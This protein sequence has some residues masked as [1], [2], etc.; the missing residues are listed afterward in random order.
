MGALL[1]IEV[2]VKTGIC[3]LERRLTGNVHL[4]AS[5]T[6]WP[7]GLSKFAASSD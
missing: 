7:L 5:E 4:T 2:R 6:Q 3:F 1:E